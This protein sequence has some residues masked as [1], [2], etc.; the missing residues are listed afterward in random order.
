MSRRL[1]I[2]VVCDAAAAELLAHHPR[3]TVVF[4]SPTVTERSALDLEPA[5]A[6]PEGVLLLTYATAAE[7]LSLSETQVRNL[8]RNREILAV[9]IGRSRRIPVTELEAF[10]ERLGQPVAS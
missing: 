3:Y 9:T 4:A 8:V 10:V 7:R 2:A 5:T 6:H 1:L